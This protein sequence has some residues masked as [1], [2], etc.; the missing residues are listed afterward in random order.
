M[1]KRSAGVPAWVSLD[2]ASAVSLHAF[3]EVAILEG[4]RRL[5]GALE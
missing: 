2:A 3:G 4:V 1:A 5:A